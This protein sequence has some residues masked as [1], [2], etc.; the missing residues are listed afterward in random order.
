MTGF[1]SFAAGNTLLATTGAAGVAKVNGTPN[2]LSYTFPNDGQAHR[3]SLYATQ[4]VTSA[5][6][7]GA[8]VLSYVDPSG[9]N[10]ANSSVFNA[11]AGAG[12]SNGTVKNV[13]VQAGSTATLKQSSALTLGATTVWAEIWGS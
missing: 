4:L 2:M 7:G 12:G 11:G 10:V 9:N 8:V 3:L 6:T 5:E 1:S 13:P